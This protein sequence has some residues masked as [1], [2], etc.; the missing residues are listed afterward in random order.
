MNLSYREASMRAQ[1]LVSH[2]TINQVAR[3]NIAGSSLTSKTIRGLALALDVS[4]TDI[5]KA[6]TESGG[7]PPVEFKLPKKADKLSPAQRKAVLAFVDALL[8]RG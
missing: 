2:A 6:I 5:E 1:G 4:V 7:K 3:G 8:E